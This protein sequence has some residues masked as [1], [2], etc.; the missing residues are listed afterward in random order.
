[1]SRHDW[2]PRIVFHAPV[3]CCFSW[4]SLKEYLSL[5]CQNLEVQKDSVILNDTGIRRGDGLLRIRCVFIRKPGV[6]FRLSPAEL[7][8]P[9]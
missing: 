3:L 6:C 4:G 2:Q 1:M 5:F 7:A 8:S 9:S